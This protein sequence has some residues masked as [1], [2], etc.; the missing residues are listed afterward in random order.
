M[1]TVALADEPVPVPETLVAIPVESVEVQYLPL[2]QRD[3]TLVDNFRFPP[4]SVVVR[5]HPAKLRR[6]TGVKATDRNFALNEGP[7]ALAFKVPVAKDL[8]SAA[9]LNL[10]LPDAAVKANASASV[11]KEDGQ[12]AFWHKNTAGVQAEISGPLGSGLKVSGENK[13][14]LTYRAPQSLGAA[15]GAD[16]LVRNQSQSAQTALDVPLGPVT[17]TL[18][19][20]TQ[21]DVTEDATLGKLSGTRSLVR[22][23]DH[24]GFVSANWKVGGGITVDGSVTTRTTAIGAASTSGS[25]RAVNPHLGI[26]FDA[27]GDTTVSAK[28]DH[29]MSGYDA[30]AYSAYTA[31]AGSGATGLVPDHAW[32]FEAEVK[33]KLGPLSLSAA[34]TADRDGTTTEFA[35]LN[36]KQVPA[37]T[38]LLER[39]RVA[40]T[41]SLPLESLGLPNS[42]LSSEAFWRSSRVLDPVTGELRTASG[43]IPREVS[44]K[45]ERK[46]PSRNLRLGLKGAFADARTAY[47]VRETSDTEAGG[48]L[49]AYLAYKPGSYEI[50]LDVDSQI[51]AASRDVTYEGARG[52]LTKIDRTSVTDNTAA[53]VKLSLRKAF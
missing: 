14:S 28:L 12:T 41:L 49:G 3:G 24:S 29:T 19:S 4:L 13:L 32:Q 51:G 10:N 33:R 25:Y 16:H 21:T 43:E 11:G 9:S 38:A 23:E 36:G 53:T 26:S 45:L 2:I 17:A 8:A 18:G 27:F 47:Q 22:S 46:L 31:V 37:S 50:A 39:D 30:A 7:V 1:G 48:R 35:A 20:S 5:Q 40:L 52:P 42:T 34:Y 15:E 44:L 6:A